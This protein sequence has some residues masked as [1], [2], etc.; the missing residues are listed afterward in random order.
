MVIK[1]NVAVAIVTDWVRDFFEDNSRANHGA[2]PSRE[3]AVV[4]V[5]V[6][7][8]FDPFV[9]TTVSEAL[10]GNVFVNGPGELVLL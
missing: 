6:D 10:V 7:V 8:Q 9:V 5:A 4:N 1:R 2:I 3:E